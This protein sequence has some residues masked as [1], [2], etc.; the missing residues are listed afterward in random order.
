MVGNLNFY[1]IC[2][3]FINGVMEDVLGFNDFSISVLSDYLE[4][5]F[6]LLILKKNFDISVLKLC[7]NFK[8]FEVVVVE[9]VLSL[10]G[11]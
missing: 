8:W 4:S 2:K 7:L 1:L 6:C 5:S 3:R 11:D 10:I 9:D